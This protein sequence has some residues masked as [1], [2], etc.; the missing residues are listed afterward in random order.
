M[1]ESPMAFSLALA[2]VSFFF[3]VIWGRAY[4]HAYQER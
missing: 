4:R 2:A 1:N 3:A